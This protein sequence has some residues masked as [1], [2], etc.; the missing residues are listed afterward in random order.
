MSSSR[1]SFLAIWDWPFDRRGRWLLTAFAVIVILACSIAYEVA[2]Y[3]SVHPASTYR[4]IIGGYR[5]DIHPFY[6]LPGFPQS[7]F[8]DHLD[9]FFEPAHRIDRLIRPVVWNPSEL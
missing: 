8:W 5:E 3:E 1:L 9:E 4:K 2:Y 6:K 7:I